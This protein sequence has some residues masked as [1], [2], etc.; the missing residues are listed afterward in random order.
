MPLQRWRE[1]D[2]FANATGKNE[3]P[4]RRPHPVH[5]LDEQTL[6]SDLEDVRWLHPTRSRF[7]FH[8]DQRAA[9]ADQ[10]VWPPN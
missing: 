6:S 3:K 8:R 4:V 10:V 1:V 2:L 5:L 7:L 9:N